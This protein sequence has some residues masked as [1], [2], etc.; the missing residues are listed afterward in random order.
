MSK[1]PVSYRRLNHLKTVAYSYGLSATDARKFGKITKTST[2]EAL[3][4][5]RVL[6]F[7]SKAEHKRLLEEG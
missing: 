1:P 6:K 2:W 4:N 5:S 3:L 7:V